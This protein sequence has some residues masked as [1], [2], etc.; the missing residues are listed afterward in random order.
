MTASITA[1]QRNRALTD[2]Q[3]SLRCRWCDCPQIN[4]A[5][6]QCR[7]CGRSMA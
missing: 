1:E 3:R 6:K 7:A 5:V 2:W 4:I